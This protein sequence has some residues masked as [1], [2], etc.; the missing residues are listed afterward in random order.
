MNLSDASL[1][2]YELGVLFKEEEYISAIKKVK[3]EA[4]RIISSAEEDKKSTYTETS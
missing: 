4:K 1:K 3:Q 2:N